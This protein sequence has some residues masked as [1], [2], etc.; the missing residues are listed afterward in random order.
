M[1]RGFGNYS[2]LTPGRYNYGRN[3]PSIASSERRSSASYSDGVSNMQREPSSSSHTTESSQTTSP[4]H[5]NI[6]DSILSQ[7]NVVPP[8]IQ[9]S[10]P[11]F[12]DSGATVDDGSAISN[13]GLLFPSTPQ[14]PQLVVPNDGTLN[15]EPIINDADTIFE[16]LIGRLRQQYGEQTDRL[17]YAQR[18]INIYLGVES[19]H[20]VLDP[21]GQASR[22]PRPHPP[23]V[24]R[25][26]SRRRKE[27]YICI[28]C[29]TPIHL[30]SRGIFKRHVNEMHQP[31]SV[32]MCM[33]CDFSN[34]RRDKLG[35]HLRI[36]HH[37]ERTPKRQ[38]IKER[39]LILPVPVECI[40]C[41]DYSPTHRPPF[42]SWDSWFEGIEMHC[43]VRDPDETLSDNGSNLHD[44]NDG[45][46]GGSAGGSFP[47][48]PF[49]QTSTSIGA[50]FG[51]GSSWQSPFSQ[52]A[53]DAHTTYGSQVSCESPNK[54]SCASLS[55]KYCDSIL[56]KAKDRSGLP[57]KHL[58]GVNID[59]PLYEDQDSILSSLSKQTSMLS[60]EYKPEAILRT[61]TTQT[62]SVIDREMKSQ[63]TASNNP[64]SVSDMIEDAELASP[65]NSVSQ[66]S[67]YSDL[68]M[69]PKKGDTYNNISGADPLVVGEMTLHRIHTDRP[70]SPEMIVSQISQCQASLSAV[71]GELS[72]SPASSDTTAKEVSR[73]RRLSSLWTRLRAVTFI[74]SLQK[75]MVDEA[76]T[77]TKPSTTKRQLSIKRH[78]YKSMAP[79]TVQPIQK[80]YNAIQSCV[81][82]RADTSKF[83]NSASYKRLMEN[84]DISGFL[85]TLTSNISMSK[86]SHI[87]SYEN[88][89]DYFYGLLRHTIANIP[90]PSF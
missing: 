84:S 31:K 18:L 46:A 86:M 57:D 35:Q 23:S 66:I 55:H 49:P 90:A 14:I 54:G 3:R 65:V 58:A 81:V 50:S 52:W 68:K 1:N 6:G 15:I 12:W 85:W 61:P 42:A 87:E 41:P 80:M 34:P 29:P 79:S 32:F 83:G 25:A 19:I 63:D 10:G 48:S 30:Y 72:A 47:S 28:L 76:A 39:E 64:P 9:E 59:T 51:Q 13:D 38:E 2:L 77:N 20:G 5:S 24:S 36:R 62:A 56:Y 69:L 53:S 26:N 88:N 89:T 27:H 21:Q 74:L 82:E 37:D 22:H 45:N 17:T 43:R 70:V 4:I 8:Y 11:F 73:R 44:H 33:Y 67:L 7:P 78:S 75:E 40:L 60:L 16:Y 71:Q